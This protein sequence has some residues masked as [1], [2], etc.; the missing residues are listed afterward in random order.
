MRNVLILAR[1]EARLTF[2]ST[3]PFLL[4]IAMPI[5]VI[6]FVSRS[7]YGGPA[8]TV[9]GL[10]TMFGLFGVTIVGLA[11]FRD[12]GWGTWDRLRASPLRP[13]EMIIGK[14]LPLVV[15]FAVQ[16]TTLLIAG[17]LLF[18]MPWAGDIVAT[19]SLIVAVVAVD[20]ALGMLAVTCC[21][22]V[23]EMT[24]AGYV[25]GILL[26]GLG[27][28]L[29]PLDRLPGWVALISPVTPV[30]WME[31]GFHVV[32]LGDRSGS[33]L[34]VSILILFVFAAVMAGFA[35]RSYRI[36]AVKLYLG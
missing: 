28:A 23:E 30:Y 20:V 18:S 19:G 15:M 13:I 22:S 14:A 25:G 16:Q 32:L 2:M 24:F 6:A 34:L 21:R 12:H 9:S 4:M 27:G 3:F 33:G 31:K 26:A 11:F 35:I 36:D 1:L 17:R 8:Q 5:L 29:T 7:Q 10:Q